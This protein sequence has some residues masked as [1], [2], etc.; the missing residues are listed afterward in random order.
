MTDDIISAD[1]YGTIKFHCEQLFHDFDAEDQQIAIDYMTQHLAYWFDCYF[2]PQCTLCGGNWAAMLMSGIKYWLPEVY[3]AMPERRYSFDELAN[4]VFQWYLI[5]MLPELTVRVICEELD[6]T[7]YLVLNMDIY[8]W[9]YADDNYSPI[10][11]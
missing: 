3:D 2:L 8:S 7:D 1:I 5:V 11:F 6:Y 10:C 4:I 9:L